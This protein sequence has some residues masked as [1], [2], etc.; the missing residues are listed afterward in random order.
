LGPIIQGIEAGGIMQEDIYKAALDRIEL[1]L[2]QTFG[3]ED[4]AYSIRA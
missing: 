4:A 1:W 3:R 2:R